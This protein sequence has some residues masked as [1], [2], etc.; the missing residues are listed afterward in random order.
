MLLSEEKEKRDQRNKKKLDEAE[1]TLKIVESLIVIN[2]QGYDESKI[3]K[4]EIML[5]RTLTN[6]AI[7]KLKELE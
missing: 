7:K 2:N 3:Q 4:V 1:Q 6:K 5:I